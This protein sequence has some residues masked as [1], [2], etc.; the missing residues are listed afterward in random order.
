MVGNRYPFTYCLPPEEIVL[1]RTDHSE[2]I[3]YAPR[4]TCRYVKDPD[5]WAELCSECGAAAIE[6]WTAGYCWACGAKV[7]S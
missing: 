3:V 6:D 5:T 1:E 4:R 7:V 2:R